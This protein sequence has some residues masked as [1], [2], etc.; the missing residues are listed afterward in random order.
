MGARAGAVLDFASRLIDN[1]LVSAGP[2][3]KSGGPGKGE[4]PEPKVRASGPSTDL[5]PVVGANLRK[6][7]TKR[8]LS[9]ERLARA[10]GVSRAM[11][12]QIEL[13]KS[14]PT[15]NVIWRIASALDLPFAALLG[16]TGARG[17]A[18][19]RAAT[20]RVLT[21]HDGAFVSRALRGE[22]LTIYGDGT[23]TRDFTFVG[24]VVAVLAEGLRRRLTHDTPVNLA[25]GSR[26]SLL[27]LVAALEAVLGRSLALRHSAPRPGDVAHSQADQELL[28]GLC[29]HVRPVDLLDGL[30]LTVDWFNEVGA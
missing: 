6:L 19:M 23:Q 5:A 9:L 4:V 29:P 20:A 14:A 16:D 1:G 11:L 7:R 8:G 2:W 15:I 24:S 25:F 22:P 28:R 30:R 3:P 26:V 18:V 10:S 12:S 21:S 17:V 27:E 13:G